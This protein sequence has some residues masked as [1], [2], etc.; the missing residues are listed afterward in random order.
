MWWARSLG[1]SWEHGPHVAGCRDPAQFT[2]GLSL[3]PSISTGKLPL[4]PQQQE[5]AIKTN[6]FPGPPLPSRALFWIPSP[7][8]LDPL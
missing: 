7:R 4:V 8:F 6:S 1:E 2:E 3:F 5:W